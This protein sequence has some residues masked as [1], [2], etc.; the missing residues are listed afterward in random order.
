VS[1]LIPSHNHAPYV[2]RAVRSVLEQTY[3][4]VELIVIDDGSTDGSVDAIRGL[5]AEGQERLTRLVFR[6]REQR[7]MGATLN[8]ALGEARGAFVCP[9]ASDDEYLPHKIETLVARRAWWDPRTVALVG[10]AEYIDEDSRP[11]RRDF[12]G[13]ETDDPAGYATVLPFLR[14][15]RPADGPPRGSYPDLLLGNTVPGLAS[16]FRRRAVV[17]VGGWPAPH[18]AGDWALALALARRGK[19][20]F[21]DAVLARYRRHRANVT[22]TDTA[23]V[24]RSAA[25]VLAEQLPHCHHGERRETWRAAATRMMSDLTA[26]GTSCDSLA[27]ALDAV[28]AS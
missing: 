20:V 15:T 27:S 8:E 12:A 14:R 22:V 19:L 11:F 2:T 26:V 10:D 25:E 3:A 23:A 16:L 4:H 5:E 24:V 28:T 17:A 9:L 6:T 21:H 13:A 7:G 1:V 18:L